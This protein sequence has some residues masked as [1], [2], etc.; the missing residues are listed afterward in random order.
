[1]DKNENLII[2]KNFLDDLKILKENNRIGKMNQYT[3]K[4]YRC[5]KGGNGGKNNK[6]Y[7]NI[8][9]LSLFTLLFETLFLFISWYIGQ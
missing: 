5:L 2:Y 8:L 4:Y 6:G 3:N 1:M 9:I 7:M